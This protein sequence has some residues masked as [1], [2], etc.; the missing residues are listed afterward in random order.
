MNGRAQTS[1]GPCDRGQQHATEP[2]Q[3]A[4]FDK[5][6]VRGPDRIAINAFGFDRLTA[7]A[8]DG[9]IEPE[10]EGPPRSADRH[11]EPQQEATGFERRPNGSIEH[12]LI[13]LK[14]RLIGFSHD[15]KNRGHRSVAG[16]KDST[17]EEEFGMLPNGS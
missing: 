6:S 14:V 3:A 7:S 13:G 1:V 12:A 10:H 11:Q 5:V 9:V 16:S 2:A 15:A 4:D 8:F 17:G